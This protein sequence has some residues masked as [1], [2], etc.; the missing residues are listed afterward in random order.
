MSS[1]QP[2]ALAQLTNSLRTRIHSRLADRNVKIFHHADPDGICAAAAAVTHIRVRGRAETLSASPIA[3]HEFDFSKLKAYL[4]TRPSDYIFCFDLNLFSQRGLIDFI[5]ANHRNR[6]TIVDDH[7]LHPDALASHPGLGEVLINPAL[8]ANST[9]TECAPSLLAYLAAQADAVSLPQWLPAIGL[10][11]DRQLE[12]YRSIFTEVLP[13]NQRLFYVG[14]LLSSVFMIPDVEESAL[15]IPLEHLLRHIDAQSSW[16][17]F[18]EAT[19]SQP[20][21]RRWR[22]VVE[23]ALSQEQITQ[24]TAIVSSERG[25]AVHVFEQSTNLRFTNIVSS[26]LRAAVP[27]GIVIAYRVDGDIAFFEI[28][29]GDKIANHD[30]VSTLNRVA[31]VLPLRNFGGHPRAAGGSCL[32]KYVEKLGAV[33]ADSE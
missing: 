23:K 28:R 20:D 11:S 2:E 7:S 25:F 12:M 26:R 31:T 10:Y 14:A 16:G 3:T 19:Q 13:S 15:Q 30:I 27:D 29:V 8:E 17:V 18:C 22:T 6:I 24:P 9:V 1:R 33:Y 21:L 32:A 4:E 5:L